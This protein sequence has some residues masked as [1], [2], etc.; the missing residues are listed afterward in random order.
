MDASPSSSDVGAVPLR[1]ASS[2]MYASRLA[3]L[4]YSLDAMLSRLSRL[5]TRRRGERPPLSV[6]DLGRALPGEAAVWSAVAR[7]FLQ[8]AA[9]SR[10]ELSASP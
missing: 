7:A 2:A 9:C 5:R 10:S 6:A 3:V 4:S 8:V 1:A